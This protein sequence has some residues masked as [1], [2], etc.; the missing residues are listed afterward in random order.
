MKKK[1]IL[2]ELIRGVRMPIFCDEEGRCE[3]IEEGA[4]IDAKEC[5]CCNINHIVKAFN[6]GIEYQQQKSPW[7]SVDEDL[8]CNHKELIDREIPTY[9]LY[10]AVRLKDGTVDSSRMIKIPDGNWVWPFKVSHWFPI[11]ELPKE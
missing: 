7:I 3:A 8:P 4:A 5:S 9:T 2:K 10:V 1:D 6:K 11:P